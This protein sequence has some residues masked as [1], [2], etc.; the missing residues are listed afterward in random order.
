M[1]SI[2]WI[3]TLTSP[4]VDRHIHVRARAHGRVRVRAR[5]FRAHQGKQEVPRTDPRQGSLKRLPGQK[6]TQSHRGGQEGNRVHLED[7]AAGGMIRHHSLGTPDS[8][9]VLH[10]TGTQTTRK[11]ARIRPLD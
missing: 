11:K 8:V 5:G 10:T 1:Y 9:P 2:L 4:G 7:Q 6:G 3:L